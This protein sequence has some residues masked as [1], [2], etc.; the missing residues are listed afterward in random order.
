M[1]EAGSER[2]VARTR[3]LRWMEILWEGASTTTREENHK[4]QVLAVFREL[5][6]ESEHGGQIREYVP[7]QPLW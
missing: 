3:S 4:E 7:W 6:R 2:T 5:A 1:S